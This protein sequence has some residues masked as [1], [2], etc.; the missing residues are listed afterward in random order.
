LLADASRNYA[1]RIG[2]AI[3]AMP[4]AK[5]ISDQELKRA[6]AIAAGR[7]HA[8]RDRLALLL[9]HWAGMRVCEAAALIPAVRSHI[10]RVMLKLHKIYMRDSK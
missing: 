7:R 2:K 3:W 1:L 6:L 4:Q 8:A 9:T 5:V 10:V